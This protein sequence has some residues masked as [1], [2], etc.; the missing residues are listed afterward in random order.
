MHS[1]GMA[2]CSDGDGHS[3]LWPALV[4]H[5]LVLGDA[6]SNGACSDFRNK[7]ANGDFGGV[8]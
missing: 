3:C 8:D 5:L 1:S 7:S 6:I 4:R 2:D